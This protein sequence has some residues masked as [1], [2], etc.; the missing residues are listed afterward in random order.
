MTAD[1]CQL[2]AR[3]FNQGQPSAAPRHN[4]D[5]LLILHSEQKCLLLDEYDVEQAIKAQTGE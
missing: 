5:G 2:A 3:T 1:A 4:L